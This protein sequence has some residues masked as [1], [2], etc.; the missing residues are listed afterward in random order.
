MMYTNGAIIQAKIK[1]IKKWRYKK[2]HLNGDIKKTLTFLGIQP[3]YKA[4]RGHKHTLSY[5]PCHN[6]LPF[7]LIRVLQSDK[8]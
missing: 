6:I 7:N 8:T 1:K 5:K 4:Y 2:K 3:I